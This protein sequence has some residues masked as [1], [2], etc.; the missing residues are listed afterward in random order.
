MV[1]NG[2]M[3]ESN[4]LGNAVLWLRWIVASRSQR[5]S[6]FAR[7]SVHVGFVVDKDAE[8]QVFSEFFR[9]TLSISLHYCYPYSYIIWVMIKRFG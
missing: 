7:V 1:A 4:D 5:R 6:R 8:G 9:L 2:G 3:T